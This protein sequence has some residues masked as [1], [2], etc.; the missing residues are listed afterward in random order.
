MLHILS[1]GYK[2]YRE[3]C[4]AGS[5][6]TVSRFSD[7]IDLI[8]LEDV[9]KLESVYHDVEDVDLYVGGVLETPGKDS[10]VGPTFRCILVD[11][12]AR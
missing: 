7:L 3:A 11:T 5:G 4:Q 6:K 8:P 10:I 1:S 12:F 2:H 9:H